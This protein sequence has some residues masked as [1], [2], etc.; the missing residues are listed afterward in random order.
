MSLYYVKMILF[1]IGFA[2]GMHS[3]N[4]YIHIVP[5]DAAFNRPDFC[6][7]LTAYLNLRGYG[8]VISQSY[9]Q[10]TKYL[11]LLVVETPEPRDQLFNYP[12]HKRCVI[13]WEP[14]SVKAYHYMPDYLAHIPLVFTWH[15]DLV[16]NI[17]F[18]KIQYQAP[19][20][21]PDTC[22]IMPWSERKLMVMLNANKL[23]G[24]A[25]ELYSKRR[26]FIE[27]CLQN[28]P[29]DF[30]LYGAGWWQ[31]P[32]YRGYVQDKLTALCGYKFNI[33][34]ENICNI[35]G[36]V[37]E[38]ILDAL[39]A[40]CVPVYWGADN[41]TDYIPEDC[42]IDRRLFASDQELYD[43]LSAM[44]FEQ[45]SKY[46]QAIDQFIVSPEAH[47]FTVDA[48]IQQLGDRMIDYIT[49]LSDVH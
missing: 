5:H 19:H 41:I 34:Y 40:G 16:D 47:Q 3:Q 36:Y 44:S 4:P 14:P 42:F 11:K 48:C 43:F 27:F 31:I 2:V 45:Y 30:D 46:L 1:T 38:K 32:V 23:S 29:Q 39:W 37:S 9:P 12:E 18:F 8:L 22:S 13:L 6:Q 10:N 21:R 26:N 24:H 28:C 17:K 35:R 33:A 15:D 20:A 7:G 25:H 49:Q